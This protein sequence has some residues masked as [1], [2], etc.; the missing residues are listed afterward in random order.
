MLMAFLLTKP[1]GRILI[2]IVVIV[3]VAVGWF[4]LQV[5]PVFAGKGKEVIVTVTQGDSLA[6]I[7]SELHQKGVI[8][9]PFAFRIDTLIFG[10]PLVQTG[11]Y[12]L[13]QGSS[14]GA[15]RSILGNAPNVDVVAVDPGLTIKEVAFLVDGV[16]GD[17]Y[18]DAFARDVRADMT[19][20]P[21]SHGSSLEGLIGAKSYLITPK[22][23]ARHLAHEMV[24]D[25]NKEAAAVGLTPTTSL[26]GLDAYQLITA[27]SIVQKEAY[28]PRYMG[29][30]A[31]VI[32][33]RLA[34]GGPL[35]MDSTVL[36]YLGQDGGTV[37]P[38]ML[39]I[40]T[41]YNTYLYTGLTP[42]PICTVSKAA[43]KGVLHAPQGTWLYFD[44]V[45]HQ[46]KTLFATT[47][48][49]QLKNEAIAKKN[50]MP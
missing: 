45:T 40:N 10:S 27:A 43:L 13:R 48:A 34:R 9:S 5:D 26:N 25:F 18:A 21:Y 37:T 31:R 8:A 20:S 49:Q 35:Q 32:Y 33:N 46:G 2:A 3:V 23:S 4:L 17:G 42:T 15:V 39:R 41:P 1:L 47:F 44:T 7:A 6:T 11:S 14:F 30:V 16:K 22:T 38:A 19:P 28:Y 36:Y 29:K 12:E 24:Q 50:G